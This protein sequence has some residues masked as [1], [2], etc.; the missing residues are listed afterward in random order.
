MFAKN[1]ENLLWQLS[2]TS[3][4]SRADPQ[5]FEARFRS[6]RDYGKLPQGRERRA[7]PLTLREVA[8]AILGLAAARPSWAGH[9]GLILANLRPVGGSEASFFGASTLEETIERILN[10]A[11]LRRGVIRL[12][13][14]AAESGTNSNGYATLT[15]VCA[16]ERRR[17]YFVPKEALSLLQPGKDLTFDP[18][19]LHSPVS[20]EMSFALSFFQRVAIEFERAKLFAS[21]PEGDGAEYDDEEAK[22][23]RYRKLG[24]HPNSMFLNVGV[25]NQVTW[26][27]NETV[28]NFDRYQFVLMPKTRENVQ[29]V[30]VDLIANRLLEREAMT[31]INRFLSIMTWCDDQFSIMQGGWSDNPVPVA[32]PKRNLAFA[33]AHDR[34]F[35]RK[36]PDSEEKRR[37]LALFREARNAEQNFM[38]SYAVLNYCKVIEIRHDG[39][40]ASKAWIE[41]NYPSVKANSQNPDIFCKFSAMFSGRSPEKYLYETC[42]NAVAHAKTSK[43][44]PDELDELTR[45]YT[46]VRVMHALAR[47]FIKSELGISDSPF[48]GD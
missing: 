47:H 10:D 24:V 8:A 27:K 11:E 14:S 35:N 41:A 40:N 33:T 20:R 43:S 4:G 48:S 16:G 28:V 29:S 7:Q 1:L 22:Q 3:D 38:V 39:K 15:Y 30:H 9:V 13:V 34:P 31:A 42:R 18:D 21:V 17:T 44:D 19:D 6:L 23:E 45:L 2:A 37:A 32:V 5:E 12:N 36:I 26:P 25:N 46:A